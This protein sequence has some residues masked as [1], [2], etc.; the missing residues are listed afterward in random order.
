MK[1]TRQGAFETNSS[2]THSITINSKNVLFDSIT[3]DSYGVINLFGGQFGWEWETYDAPIVKANY[4]AIHALGDL[5][6]T[7][8]L[9]NVIKVHTGAKE[10]KI[11]ASL[12]YDNRNRSYIDHQS[13]GTANDAFESEETLKNFIFN[14]YSILY[15]GNDNDD[16]PAN[17]YDADVHL[18]THEV[19]LEGTTSSKFFIHKNDVNNKEKL[20]EAIHSLFKDGIYDKYSRNQISFNRDGDDGFWINSDDDINFENKTVLVSRKE[21]QYKNDTFDGYKV[22]EEK[23]LTFDV[24]DRTAKVN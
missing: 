12:D 18:M 8:M 17:F 19:T 7:E 23:K 3:P 13:V 10:V 2:S 5:A 22:I 24:I 11:H 21:A 1:T 20:A 4:C 14:R 6:Q 15:T 16:A 9:V